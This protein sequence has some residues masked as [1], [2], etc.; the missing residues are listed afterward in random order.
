MNNNTLKIQLE[1]LAKE[2]ESLKVEDV[3]SWIDENIISLE[4]SNELIY[5]YGGPSIRIYIDSNVIKGRD[6]PFD[7]PIFVSR[8]TSS[9]EIYLCE[10]KYLDN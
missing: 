1:E 3:P 8:N 10:F 2:I 4:S 6:G 5:T 9:L 7:E